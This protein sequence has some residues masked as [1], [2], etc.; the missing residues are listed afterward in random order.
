MPQLGTRL[1]GHNHAV[2]GVGGAC[3]QVHI[4]LLSVVAH[5]VLVGLDAA[6]A[7][8]HAAVGLDVERLAV[9]LNHAADDSALGVEDEVLAGA[10]M[11]HRQ[12]VAVGARVEGVDAQVV[13][14]RVEGRRAHEDVVAVVVALKLGELVPQRHVAGAAHTP[15]VVA[16]HPRA[17][18]HALAVNLGRAGDVGVHPQDIDGPVPV[19]CGAFAHG[20]QGLLVPVLEL[21]HEQ[22]EVRVEGVGVVG[23]DDVLACGVGVAGHRP[24]GRLLH[25]EDLHALLVGSHGGIA[26]GCAQAHDHDV[27]LGV[28]RHL[29]AR[30]VGQR[31]VGGGPHGDGSQC[32]ALEQRAAGDGVLHTTFPLGLVDTSL[33]GDERPAV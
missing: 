1:L 33:P 14:G 29:G 7:Q 11:P 18:T 2:A 26:A 28:P 19:A 12:P 3:L 5:H 6:G 25:G 10:G 22:R 23:S 21:A 30:V 20:A 13:V 31:D 15:G 24:L 27:I 4:R 32:G 16:V 8:A 9:L 17:G